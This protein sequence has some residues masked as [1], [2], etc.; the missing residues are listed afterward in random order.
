VAA[1]LESFYAEQP[2]AVLQDVNLPDGSGLDALLEYK[3]RQPQAIVI[4]ITGN[5]QFEDTIAA[6]RGRAYDFIAKPVR[7]GELQVAIRNG[8]EAG[9]LR[10][11]VR[12]LRMEQ[13][14]RFSKSRR[15]FED[16][17]GRGTSANCATSSNG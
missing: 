9:R 16:I 7:L 17:P 15:F 1:A 6:L 4:M 3:K 2:S 13:E 14:R 11:E 12:Y 10:R 5:V 8:I